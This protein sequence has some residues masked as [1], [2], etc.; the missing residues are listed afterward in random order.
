MDL[1]RWLVI[2]NSIASRLSLD[3]SKDQDAALELFRLLSLKTPLPEISLRSKISGKIA[4]VYGAGPSLDEGLRMILESGFSGRL[5]HLV[6]DGASSAFLECGKVPD[7]IFT[8]LDGPAADLTRSCSAGAWLVVHAHGDNIP[9]LRGLVP[10]LGCPILGSTQVHPIPPHVL[11]FGGFTD[12][13]RAAYWAE[14]LGASG[15]VLVGMDFGDEIGRRSKPRLQGER[16][17]L[18]LEKLKI[19][20]ELVSALAAE[21]RIFSLKAGR[22]SVPNVIPIGIGELA[23]M[24]KG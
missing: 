23:E 19:G 22:S 8:D 21:N 18:K 5:I 3:P 7:I 15:V 4:V 11:N 10:G 20:R 1:E 6:A 14:E 9:L 13:D 24:V 16:L 2:Y 17:K 12:G